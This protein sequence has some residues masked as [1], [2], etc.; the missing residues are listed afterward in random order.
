[1]SSH[2]LRCVKSSLAVRPRISFCLDSLETPDTTTPGK[3]VPALEMI[4][5]SHNARAAKSNNKSFPLYGDF[6]PF[7]RQCLLLTPRPPAMWLFR[8]GKGERLQ[9]KA[10]WILGIMLCHSHKFN[11]TKTPQKRPKYT[12]EWSEALVY[13]ITRSQRV[14]C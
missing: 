6:S 14:F 13:R 10:I 5:G 1:M 8:D 2:C 12:H 11:R 3:A 4:E 7:T 9:P